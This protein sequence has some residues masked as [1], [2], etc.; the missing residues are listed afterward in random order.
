VTSVRDNV[1]VL[2]YLDISFLKPVLLRRGW[3]DEVYR[4]GAFRTVV[5]KTLHD[6]GFYDYS[7][8]LFHPFGM[9]LVEML[10]YKFLFFDA[11]DNFEKI[12]HLSTLKPSIHNHYISAAA[13]AAAIFTV[14]P[15]AKDSLFAGH[16]NVRVISNGVDPESF[17]PPFPVHD[18]SRLKRSNRIKLG[19]V[20]TL[21]HRIDLELLEAV[22]N[23]P[24][25]EIFLIGPVVSKSYFAR[26]SRCA[27]V[28]FHHN[29]HYSLVPA[30]LQ[31]FD[32][33]ILPHR[34]GKNENDGNAIKLYEYIAAGKPVISTP[35]KGTEPFQDHIFVVNCADG[36]RE[37]LNS[38]IESRF[39]ITYPTDILQQ[40]TWQLK[41]DQLFSSIAEAAHEC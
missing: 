1:F 36:F 19:Y 35:I 24:D 38:L 34:L 39:Q 28:I 20:G 18:F 6:L 31:D 15:E 37:A 40:F 7:V 4:S 23:I 11:I 22:S 32:V 33:C 8:L 21:S 27:N 26:L 13:R 10:S 2:D 41:A 29:I 12:E 5:E 30:I 16:K 17:R 14:S 9:G 3:W 25:V